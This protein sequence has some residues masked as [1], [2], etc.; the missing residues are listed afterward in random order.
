[1]YAYLTRD[2]KEEQDKPENTVAIEKEFEKTEEARELIFNKTKA[3]LY[4]E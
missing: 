4:N 3:E 1:V 2:C